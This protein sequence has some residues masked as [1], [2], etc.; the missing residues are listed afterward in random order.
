MMNLTFLKFRLFPGSCFLFALIREDLIG[1]VCV[2]LMCD[3]NNGFQRRVI[4]SCLEFI[5][6][7]DFFRFFIS[8]LYDCSS[9]YLL[10]D[11]ADSLHCLMVSFCDQS[12]HFRSAMV[13]AQKFCK[14]NCIVGTSVILRS[15]WGYY[16]FFSYDCQQPGHMRKLE[17]FS[18]FS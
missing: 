18:D 11:V 3:L 9:C 6:R 17:L 12:S 16:I 4:V 7:I 2:K 15:V 1:N 5:C 8:Y 10:V 14:Y 13:A